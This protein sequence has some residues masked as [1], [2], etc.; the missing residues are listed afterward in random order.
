MVSS[1]TLAWRSHAESVSNTKR[2]GRPAAKPRPSMTSARRSPRNAKAETTLPRLAGLDESDIRAPCWGDLEA[3]A[4][5]RQPGVDCCGA[6]GE[7]RRLHFRDWQHRDR[8]VALESG[9]AGRARRVR[10][11][12]LVVRGATC[13][14]CVECYAAG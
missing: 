13:A 12:E 9:R 5:R 1:E 8:N 3:F 14:P 10:K 2:K 4:K 6:Q 11:E 7:R